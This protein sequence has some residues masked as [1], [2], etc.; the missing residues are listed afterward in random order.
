[1]K[2]LITWGNNKLGSIGQFNLP[3]ITT[4]GKMSKYCFQIKTADGYQLKTRQDN[5]KGFSPAKGDIACYA[6]KGYCKD[7]RRKSRKNLIYINRLI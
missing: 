6:C 5:N 3:P 1:M 7:Q 4:C 2:N